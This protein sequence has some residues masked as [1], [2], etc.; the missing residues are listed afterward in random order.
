MG[1]QSS[2]LL[3]LVVLLAVSM[4]GPSRASAQEDQFVIVKYGK[5]TVKSPVPE[6]KVYIDDSYKGPADTVIE[7]V[8]VGDHT[9][10]CRTDTQSATG[11]FQIKKDE[12]L[13]LEAHYDSG[14]L[15]PVIE[16]KEVEKTEKVEAPV[17]AEPEKKHKA[18]TPKPQPPKKAVVEAKREEKKNPVEERRATYLNIIKVFFD[19]IDTD[20]VRFSYKA[21]PKAT[22]RYQEK[23]SRTGTYYRTKKD[24]LLCD[25]GP[26]VQQWSASFV[27]TDEQGANETFSLTWKQTV[28]NGMTPAGTSKRDLLF[29]LSG[30]CQAMEDETPDSAAL[31][32]ENGRY[33][34][35]WRK[36]SL[37]IRRTDIVK[38]IIDSG[39]AVDAY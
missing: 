6:A 30:V 16:R 23:K 33:Q 26:C 28:F 21:N 36:T 9:I 25:K 35:T 14:K 1:K 31:T 17:K 5:V 37:V 39:G 11:M 3:P 8:I 20:D 10:S 32:A 12:I 24:L 29:C 18:E 4:T 27:Y 22:N 15:A 2:L 13:K 19:D 7:N 38:E 34:A